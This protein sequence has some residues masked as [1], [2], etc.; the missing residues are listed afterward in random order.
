MYK[1]LQNHLSHHNIHTSALNTHNKNFK[2]PKIWKFLQ[3][4]LPEAFQKVF[5]ALLM[6]IECG[7][8]Q[9]TL[10]NGG[11][12]M[13]TVDLGEDNHARFSKIKKSF[14]CINDSKKSGIDASKSH[15]SSK[16]SS[17]NNELQNKWLV[18]IYKNMSS[19]HEPN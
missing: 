2:R 10:F 3:E 19:V 4:V 17:S 14:N 1:T 13:R 12:S 8:E 11:R 15:R 7:G 16:I 5:Q 18:E 9:H 6:Q